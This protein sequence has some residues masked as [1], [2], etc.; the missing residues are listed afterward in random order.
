MAKFDECGVEMA[1]GGTCCCGHSYRRRTLVMR[2]MLK[3][4]KIKHEI[5]IV[6]VFTGH[7]KI[8]K[9]GQIGE[10]RKHNRE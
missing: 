9:Q 5:D 10:S 2:G 1:G 3:M 6:A 8:E 4:K 7:I